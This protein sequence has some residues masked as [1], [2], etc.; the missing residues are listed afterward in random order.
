MEDGVKRKLKNKVLMELDLSVEPT[1][2]DISKII[3][4]CILEE[5]RSGYLPLKEKVMLRKELF[6][7]LR[8]LDVLTEYLE[9]DGI[10]EIMVNG[11][12]NIYLEK[13]G[14]IERAQ[15]C[16]ESE[17]KLKSV[18]QQIVADC[19]R[20]VNE[21]NPIVDARLKDGSRVNMVLN[22]VALNGPVI[23]IRK[24]PNEVMTLDRLVQLEALDN[25]AADFL[26]LLVKAGYN[27]FISGGTGSGK[28]TFL[29]ALSGYIPKDER[30]ITIEDAAELQI[31]EIPNLISL[32]ARSANVEGENEI[33]IRDLIKTSLRMRPDRIIVGEVRDAAAIDMLQAMNTGHDGSLSTGHANSSEDMLSRLETMVLMGMDIPL[34]AVRMQIASAI[35]II[36][37]LGRMRDKS[38]RVLEISEVLGVK[39][40]EIEIKKLYE[41]IETG[42]VK[43]RIKGS[44]K[45][46]NDLINT[47]K[48]INSGLYESYKESMD[49][50]QKV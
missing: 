44:L 42:E 29:N 10:T 27:I 11:Y 25:Q 26:K 17:E 48:L 16:F 30:V 5:D 2:D 1:D 46:L 6:N 14:K 41:F 32:E 23:T 21:A 50:L 24:F 18:V 45:R 7:S 22:P 34:E 36:I 13:H 15:K 38:R 37:H 20:R 43:G 8:R 4:R 33:T 31:K 9:D 19:N 3:D 39:M 28:T 12:N 35:D 40:G 49:G 47:D